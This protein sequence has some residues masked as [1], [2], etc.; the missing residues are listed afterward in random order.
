[1]N[2]RQFK[3]MAVIRNV[4]HYEPPITPSSF[5]CH[6]IIRHIPPLQQCHHSHIPRRT[7]ARSYHAT[8][9]IRLVIVTAHQTTRSRTRFGSMNRRTHAYHIT[10]PCLALINT[11]AN[12][13]GKNRMFK[14]MPIS[15]R[16]Q[17]RLHASPAVVLFK[18][19]P[20]LHN[21]G[22]FA[23]TPHQPRLNNGQHSLV[24]STSV[25]HGTIVEQP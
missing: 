24:T 10:P 2:Q 11:V 19:R 6:N 25:V 21:T 22:R 17:R 18:C 13:E 7:K 14:Q 16:S 9:I 23:D 20:G 1:M 12:H 3:R 4:H 8:I 5:V 15:Y